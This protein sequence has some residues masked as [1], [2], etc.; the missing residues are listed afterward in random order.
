MPTVNPEAGRCGFFVLGK[1]RFCRFQ[2]G[3]D[4][5]CQFHR[6]TVRGHR[7][8]PATP[9]PAHPCAR[10]EAPGRQ[11]CPN[12]CGTSI[13]TA[14]LARHLKR[15]N[16]R[17]APPPPYFRRG[18]NVAGA[19]DGDAAL[20][21][22]AP[23]L[24]SVPAGE[25]GA[26]VRRVL[27]AHAEHA[28]PIAVAIF[29]HPVP[30]AEMERTRS[31]EGGGSGGQHKHLEQQASLIGTMEA[32]GL[33]RPDSVFVE[34]GAGRAKLLHFVRRSVGEQQPA[35]YLAV[36]RDKTRYNFDRFHPPDGPARCARATIDIADLDLPAAP[37]VRDGGQ[38]V[39]FGK[40]L[41]GGATDL[42]LRCVGRCDAGR[43]NGIM[44]ALCCHQLCRWDSYVNRSF[45]LD[46]LRFSRREFE[47][48]TKMSSWAVCGQRHEPECEHAAVVDDGA[49]VAMG[50]DR[51]AEVG[52]ACKRLLDI[53]RLKYLRANGYPEARLQQYTDR[54]VTLENVL[55]IATPAPP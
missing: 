24:G 4:G 17:S 5:M 45:F 18:V 38:L 1:R 44:V 34:F 8:W 30:R 47:L 12:G 25:L 36:D 20:A 26:L 40:H 33:L 7:P 14:K 21:V 15:C 43:V 48:V 28:E 54:A 37:L 53:G 50:T 22:T 51:R 11:L 16:A 9:P 42:T 52:R 23:A 10:Q 3:P 46:T 31:Q 55:L 35:G 49:G 32:H 39:A 13:A 6:R 29:D 27:A 2:A 41:C 19:G